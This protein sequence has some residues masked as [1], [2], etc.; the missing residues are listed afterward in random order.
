MK[1]MTIARESVV[2][3]SPSTVEALSMR[4]S[5]PNTPGGN[6]GIGEDASITSE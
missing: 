5:L 1:R 2:R 3:T 4:F 6:P